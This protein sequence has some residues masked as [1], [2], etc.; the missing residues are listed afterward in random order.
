M[1]EQHANEKKQ[2]E[3]SHEKMV[4]TLNENFDQKMANKEQEHVK[5]ME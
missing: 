3:E 1:K 4:K 2:L 5:A